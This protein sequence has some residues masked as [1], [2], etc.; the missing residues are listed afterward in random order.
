MISNL[1]QIQDFPDRVT[2]MLVKELRQILRQKSFLITFGIYLLTLMLFTIQFFI[3][4]NP[5]SYQGKD[6]ASYFIRQGEALSVVLFLILGFVVIILQPA[7]MMQSISSELRSKTCELLYLTKLTAW[8]IVL[9]KWISCIAQ[10]FLFA[11]TIVPFLIMRYYLGGMNL[12]DELL[13]MFL[14]FCSGAVLSAISLTISA[15]NSRVLTVAAYIGLFSFSITILTTISSI[16]ILRG[17]GILGSTSSSVSI[18][19]ISVSST[20]FTIFSILFCMLY[21]GYMFLNSAAL[22]IAPA[23]EN[24][25]TARRKVSILCLLITSLLVVIT[26]EEA[27][28]YF[29]VIIFSLESF[30]SLSDRFETISPVV[31]DLLK[32]RGIFWRLFRPLLYPTFSSGVLLS[33]FLFFIMLGSSLVLTLGKTQFLLF[34][35][36][37]VCFVTAIYGSTIFR[38]L[39]NRFLANFFSSWILLGSAY[40]MIGFFAL[41]SIMG[42]GSESPSKVFCH[43]LVGVFNPTLWTVRLMD[44]PFSSSYSSGNAIQIGLDFYRM[45][46]LIGFGTVAV[47]FFHALILWLL[48]RKSSRALRVLK[49]N[50]AAETTRA[51]NPDAV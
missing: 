42:G 31:R 8:K 7:R 12:F 34:N 6:L 9:G 21:I 27:L 13:L 25:S 5:D 10:N 3:T 30:F 32:S 2:P 46:T 35:Y 48:S 40:M 39:K 28:L 1:S 16:G 26:K 37:S 36:A 19:G 4:P 43:F 44:N 51:E 20:T 15:L 38:N 33:L 11:I 23:A 22:L 24:H 14:I 49:R 41:F 29:S 45:S 50:V 18:L 17:K 47:F